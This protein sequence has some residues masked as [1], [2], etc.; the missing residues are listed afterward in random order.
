[1]S[2]QKIPSPAEILAEAI[3]SPAPAESCPLRI[4]RN[5]TLVGIPLRVEHLGHDAILTYVSAIAG[6][7]PVV[8]VAPDPAAA[9]APADTPQE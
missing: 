2:D 1:M 9:D 4:E 5:G 7:E 3:A 6:P 8:M